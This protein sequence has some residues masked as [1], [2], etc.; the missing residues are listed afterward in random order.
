MKRIIIL[1]FILLTTGSTQVGARYLIIAHDNFYNEILPLAD[2]KYRKGMKSKVVKLSDIGSSASAIRDYIA[3]AYNTWDIPPEYVLL[4]GAPNYI[5][6]PT[7][8]GTYSDN[9]YTNIEGGIHN[10]ILSGRLTVHNTT[11]EATVVNK[12]MVYERYPY[13]ENP[14]WFKSACLMVRQDYDPPDDSIYWSDLHFA[15]ANMVDNGFVEIDSFS[16]LYGNN[17]NDLL[18]SA[19]EGRAFFMYRGSAINN[20]WTPFNVNPENLQNGSQLPIVMSITCSCMGTGSTPATAERWLLT[21]TPTEPK[22]GAGY[23]A[24]TTVISGGAH[25]RSAVA[26]GFHRTLFTGN[27]VTFGQACEGAR[28]NVYDLYPSSGGLYEYLGFTT[29]GDPEMLI[30]KDTPC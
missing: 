17:V 13:R 10:D 30:W 6:F 16:D 21:G 22:G 14:N 29:L 24:T 2:W 27:A 3:D 18:N 11:E 4:V 20:W 23:F 12:I 26:K 5:P 7:V 25:L 19:S 15:A 8:S 28:A 9:Y 1:S